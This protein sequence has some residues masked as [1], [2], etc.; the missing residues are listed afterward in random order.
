MEGDCVK[1]ALALL[2]KAGHMDLVNLEALSALRPARKV[3]QGVTG[4]VLA[5]GW[6]STARTGRV[7]PMAACIRK[8]G[9]AFLQPQRGGA[10]GVR[11]TESRPGELED[12]LGRG[13]S[14]GPAGGLGAQPLIAGFRQGP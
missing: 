10:G 14:R 5:L 13:G 4:S 3:A 12:T 1:K 9:R 8:G 7:V 11:A 6:A 2:E